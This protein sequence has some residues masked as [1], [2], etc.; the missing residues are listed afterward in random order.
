MEGIIILLQFLLLLTIGA[1]LFGT[2]KIYRFLTRLEEEVSNEVHRTKKA[3]SRDLKAIFEFQK[4]TK[5]GR[6]IKDAKVIN[7]DES[8]IN[9]SNDA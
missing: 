4:T 6:D 3:L 1:F 9:D 5:D 8:V 2:Y 7:P